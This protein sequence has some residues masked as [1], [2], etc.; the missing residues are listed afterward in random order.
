MRSRKSIARLIC[1]T[2]AVL[3]MAIANS[4]IAHNRT[5]LV[6]SDTSS[7][8]KDFTIYRPADLGLQDSPSPVIVWG[9]GGCSLNHSRWLPIIRRLTSEGY[10]VIATGEALGRARQS[11]PAETSRRYTD[12][13]LER[14]VD[15]VE[16]A[17]GA[18]DTVYFGQLD[19]TRIARSCR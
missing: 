5:S 13:D 14:A 15:W 1:Q 17:N 3:L 6:V 11:S 7:T 4:S 9:N 18:K 10:V 16:E 8:L 2:A 19:L 12:K